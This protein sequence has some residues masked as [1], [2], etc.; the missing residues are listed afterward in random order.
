MPPLRRLRRHPPEGAMP[1]A[2]QSQFH[3]ILDPG[4]FAGRMSLFPHV[5]TDPFATSGHCRTAQSF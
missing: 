3:G 5:F 2:L 4:T 1:V